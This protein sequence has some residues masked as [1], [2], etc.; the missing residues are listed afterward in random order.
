[1]TRYILHIGLHKTGTSS[2]QAYL[3]SRRQM[4]LE[5]GVD[6]PLVGRVP[7][8][9]QAHRHVVA[10]FRG[11]TRE[12]PPGFGEQIPGG[13]TECDTCILSSE[14]FYFCSGGIIDAIATALGTDADVICYLREPVSHVISMYKEHLK[15]PVSES[16]PQFIESYRAAMLADSGFSYYS[17][18]RNLADWR[19]HFR[20]V[21]APYRREGMI[22]DFV[23]RSGLDLH[24]DMS[25]AD[26]R[27]NTSLPEDAIMLQ[28][29]IGRAFA[30]SLIDNDEWQVLRRKI[31]NWGRLGKLPDLSAHRR[32]AEIDMRPFL[33]AFRTVNPEFS[34]LA[35][36][37]Q[38]TVSF[39]DSETLDHAA[40]LD[41]ARKHF[42][43]EPARTE[44]R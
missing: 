29:A 4:L 1:M 35:A 15:R 32:P 6:F 13:L 38:D 21:A 33:A 22:A 11:Q 7:Q 23:T 5:H 36:G 42:G 30:G 41:I 12:Y 25:K 26:I 10:W 34:G 14:D 37:A 28:L 44:V 9:S 19:R 3:S 16:F 40:V 43:Q 18:S 2:L 20:V 31:I 24:D 8:G 27:E 39:W 17:Y